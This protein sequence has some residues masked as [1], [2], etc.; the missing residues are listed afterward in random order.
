MPT[1]D[2][3]D[4]RT[5]FTGTKEGKRMLRESAAAQKTAREQQI[6]TIADAKTALAKLEPGLMLARAKAQVAFDLATAALATANR[7]L[8]HADREL[9][10]A[11]ATRDRVVNRAETTLRA[12]ADAS[13]DQAKAAIARKADHVRS[14]GMTLGLVRLDVAGFERSV[15]DG[16]Y[17][18]L[19]AHVELLGALLPRLDALKLGADPA[20]IA[21]VNAILA[22][23]GLPAIAVEE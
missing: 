9:R 7:D 18:E 1:L 19:V 15:G 21:E 14:S 6:D 5:W 10:S 11:R 22:E 4:F 17:G 8:V 3:L 16:G 2:T 23:A 13:I 20:P 12:S